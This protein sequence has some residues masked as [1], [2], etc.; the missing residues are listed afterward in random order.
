MPS[1]CETPS[2]AKMR[3][4]PLLPPSHVYFGIGAVH[5][6]AQRQGQVAFERRRVERHQMRAVQVGNQGADLLDQTRPLEQFLRERA[7]RA[8]E[9]RDQEQALLRVAGQH[10]R[11]QVEIVVDDLRMDRL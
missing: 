2:S 11:Q 3:R 10:A 1:G 4:A 8:V 6:D 5:R 7:R 9:R